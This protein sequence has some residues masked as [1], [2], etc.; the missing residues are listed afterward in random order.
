RR[1]PQ[2]AVLYRVRDAAA[3]G[4]HRRVRRDRR[5]RDVVPARPGLP[6]A[7]VRGRDGAPAAVTFPMRARHLLLTACC[8]LASLP[9]GAQTA[10]LSIL[11]AEDRRAPTARDLS[12]L[13]AGVR[14][15]NAR[16]A[17]RALGRLERPALISD[18][19]PS[20][21]HAL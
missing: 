17:V 6:D 5:R 9:A 7:G 19:L 14:G 3:A 13:R 16:L 12:I 20:L 18:L 10:V 15:A 21:R 11:Q 8:L 2:P 1:S 4:G